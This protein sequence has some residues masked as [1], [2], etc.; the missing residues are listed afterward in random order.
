LIVPGQN[1]AIKF[2]K[3]TRAFR[4]VPA[5][6]RGHP[7]VAARSTAMRTIGYFRVIPD[8]NYSNFEITKRACLE[9]VQFGDIKIAQP[10][11]IYKYI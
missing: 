2:N 1:G 5:S 7:A 4:A 9:A 10:Y 8:C 6:R 11:Y 3:V